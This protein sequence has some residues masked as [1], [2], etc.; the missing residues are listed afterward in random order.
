MLFMDKII[1]KIKIPLDF[2][3]YLINFLVFA[4]NSKI[5]FKNRQPNPEF[6]L[7]NFNKKIKTK[8]LQF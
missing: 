2:K 4:L 6:N 8:E 7:K 1:K 5:I 3:K